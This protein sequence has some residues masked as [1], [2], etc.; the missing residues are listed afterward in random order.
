LLRALG[1]RVKFAGVESAGNEKFAGTF[2]RTLE[3]IRCLDFEK[4]LLVEIITRR[5]GGLAPHAQIPIHGRTAQVEITVLQ[6]KVLINLCRLL[7]IERKRGGI[8]DIVNDQPCGSD[9]NFAG[10]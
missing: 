7:I 9:F 3:Q 4:I 2:R 8:G 6:P 10:G 5:L 1:Q